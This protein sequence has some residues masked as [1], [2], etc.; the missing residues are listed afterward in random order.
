MNLKI[1]DI[2]GVGLASVLLFPVIFFAV[3]LGTGTAHLEFGEDSAVRSKLLGY[4]EKMN[5]AQ[6]QHDLE[7]SRLFEANKKKEGELAASQAKLQEE[8][9]RMES[10]KAENA[11]LKEAMGA[12]RK[13]IEEMVDQSKQLSDQRIEEL[14]LIYGAM[15]PVE[16]APILL[17]LDDLTVAKILKRVP[18]TRSQAKIMAAIGAMDSKRAAAITQILGWKKQGL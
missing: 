5:P 7:Q 14:A 2:I 11:R 18:E 12:D 10:M 9:A 6:D 17:N 4:L 16:S 13:R 15:K 3:L 1:T 8:I